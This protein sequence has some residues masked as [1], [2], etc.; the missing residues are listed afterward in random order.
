MADGCLIE[1][2]RLNSLIIASEKY[3]FEQIMF[4]DFSDF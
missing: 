2:G 4:V 3:I 1:R